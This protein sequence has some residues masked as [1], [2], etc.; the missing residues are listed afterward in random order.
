LIRDFLDCV[1]SRKTPLCP[2]EEGH[3]STS[4]AH[5]ANIALAV[6]E[7]LQWDAANERFVN[8]EKANALLSYEYRQPWKL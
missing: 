2:L 5:L 7:R 1:K 8:N 4:L 3:R 6:K